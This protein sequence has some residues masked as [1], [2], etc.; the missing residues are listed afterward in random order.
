MIFKN[1]LYLLSF[2]NNMGLFLFLKR[3]NS[4]LEGLHHPTPGVSWEGKSQDVSQQVREQKF[5]YTLA[6]TKSPI[7]YFKNWTF[8]LRL[9]ARLK[10][11]HSYPFAPLNYVPRGNFFFFSFFLDW[12]GVA[13]GWAIWQGWDCKNVLANV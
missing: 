6:P 9:R 2:I 7:S 8:T 1:I 11:P 4:N 3:L 12:M 10:L 13:K 5:A